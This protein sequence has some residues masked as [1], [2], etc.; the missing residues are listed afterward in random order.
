MSPAGIPAFYGAEDLDTVIDEIRTVTGSRAYW[1]AGE[2]TTS[3]GCILLDL[4]TM[5]E[6]PTIF[7]AERRRL[8]RPLYFLAAFADEISKP[9]GDQSRE[10]IDYVPTQVVAEFLRLSPP[11]E[12]G[13]VAGVRYRSARHEGGT[14]VVLFVPHDDCVSE[15]FGEGLQLVLGEVRHGVFGVQGPA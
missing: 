5:P 15:A 6:P 10:H 3:R 4:A 12:L 13:P 1:S 14:C 11:S 2:F 8:R 7:D 9:L